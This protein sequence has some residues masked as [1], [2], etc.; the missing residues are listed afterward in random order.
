M[1]NTQR[2]YFTLPTPE[3]TKT[4]HFSTNCWY[5]LLEDTGMQL[6]AF[7]NNLDAQLKDPE[8][9]MLNIVN[10]ITDLA[11][12]AAKAYDQEESNEIEYNRFKV[13][14]WISNLSAEQSEEFMR[15]M[16]SSIQAPG[17]KEAKGK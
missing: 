1:E 10:S 15:A 16:M 4:L 11:Y 13:R 12:A 5:N 14:T 17:K 7:G 6:D 8:A 3:G 9:N 2:G